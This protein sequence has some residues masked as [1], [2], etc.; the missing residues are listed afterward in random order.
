MHDVSEEHD[1]FADSN[2]WAFNA[3]KS[4]VFCLSFAAIDAIFYLYFLSSY[5]IISA[6]VL[7]IEEPFTTLPFSRVSFH[8]ARPSRNCFSSEAT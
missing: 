5:S 1:I 8:L 4:I 6:N 2:L 7:S 3:K